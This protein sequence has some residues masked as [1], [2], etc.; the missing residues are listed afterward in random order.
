MQYDH[1]VV[2][3]GSSGAVIASRLSEDPTRQV[4]LLEA[5]PDYADA[6]HTP[7]DLLQ[8]HEP[9][10]QGHNWA[11]SALIRE[12]GLFDR[13]HEAHRVFGAA[14]SKLALARTALGSLIGG[15]SVLTRFDYPM[16]RVMGGSSA[17]N[18][19]LAMRGAPED[20]EEW[21]A[22]GN[23]SWTWPRVLD[24]FRAMETD[25]DVRGPY[26]GAHGPVPVSRTKLADLHDVQRSFMD[27]CQAMGFATGDI[28]HPMS[29][30]CGRVPRNVKAGVR[31]SSAMAYLSKAR[32]RANLHI[33]PHTLVDR[34]MLQGSRATGVEVIV[35]GERLK[36]TGG[37]V[38]LSAGA[39]QTPAILMRSGIGPA[40]VLREAGV[41]Q[42]VALN[43]VGRNLMDHAAVG[44][45]MV[46][47]EGV[48]K[49]GE[50]LH[51]A[52]LRHT[53]KAGGQRNDLQL[54][55]LNSVRT[56]QFPELESA[57]GAS[58]AMALSAVLSK[59]D[60]RG[61]IDLP[62][63]DPMA[64]PHIT[65]NL[66][67]APRDVEVLMEGV[68]LAWQIIQ[69][70]PLASHVAKV[71]AWNQRIIDDDTLLRQTIS[72][73]VRGSWH[74]AGTARMGLAS[75]AMAVTDEHGWVHG[76]S[77]LMVADASLMPTITR[78]PTNL[79]CLMIGEMVSQHLMEA[80][81][82]PA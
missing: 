21:A 19:A 61:W 9:V 23:P 76:C 58:L 70:K 82:C 36:Y 68:R 43:G 7:E 80:A 72:T 57:L 38:V 81:A 67:T 6:A 39:I 64:M 25:A 18:G 8:P 30:G 59:P 47:K 20:Y 53:S 51:Q 41:S 1:I 14:S 31:V 44:L 27:V 10:T 34:V 16:G 69:T 17:V 48:C 2:G 56:S 37:H 3:G 74:P 66:A 71:F 49:A 52:T 50:D 78:S 29:T 13:V 55:M 65:L 40:D 33:R 11:M 42:T 5:G 77:R 63:A 24:V 62:S 73:F 35:D 28:A 26:S 12:Q 79:T 32:S 22:Q 60:S 15:S 75:D 54:F 4:L 45:W 46:P